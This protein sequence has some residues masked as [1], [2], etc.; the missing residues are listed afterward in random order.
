[1]MSV[2]LISIG[3]RLYEIGLR[4][5]IGATHAQVFMQFLVESA[6][7]SLVGGILGVGAGIGITKAVSS[8]FSGGLPIH[9][10]GVLFSLGVSLV[11]GILYG[12]YPAMKASRMEPVEAL[13]AAT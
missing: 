6:V 2:M 7:L 3:E 8:F 5:A 1:L 9:L 13:R 12:I 10:M 4:K 11:L